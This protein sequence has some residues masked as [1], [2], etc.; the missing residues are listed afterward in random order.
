MRRLPRRTRVPWGKGRGARERRERWVWSSGHERLAGGEAKT[1]LLRCGREH[2]PQPPVMSTRSVEHVEL[3]PTLGEALSQDLAGEIGRPSG[4]SLVLNV[5]G[6][7]QTR[8]QTLQALP[9]VRNDLS[10]MGRWQ[11]GQSR[12]M[13]KLRRRSS[14]QGRQ[15]LRRGRAVCRVVAR[16]HRLDV[17]FCNV[18]RRYWVQA[19][20]ES[21]A[22]AMLRLVPE[23]RRSEPC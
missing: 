9:P 3:R 13:S 21:R 4:R 12:S 15:R 11:R 20:E 2:E 22:G 23:L 16:R 7:C 5:S 8:E 17:G 18:V 14:S 10:F 6:L 1:Q 19:A